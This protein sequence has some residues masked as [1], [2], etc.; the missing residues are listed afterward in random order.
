MTEQSLFFK[1][2]TAADLRFDVDQMSRTA[3]KLQA[4][5]EFDQAEPLLRKV[6]EVSRQIQGDKDPRTLTAVGNLALLLMQQG[7]LDQAEPLLR[8]AL[9]LSRQILGSRHPTTL[10][11]ISVL[12]DLLHQQGI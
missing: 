2:T 7:K 3:L 12:S 11:S 10:A 4:Q 5:G 9:H 8:N 1:N 6:L